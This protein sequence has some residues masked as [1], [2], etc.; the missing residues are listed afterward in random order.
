MLPGAVD[1]VRGWLAAADVV[2]LPS[3]W[4]GLSLTVLEAMAT[5]R[6]VVIS[7]VPGLTEALG[8]GTG[9]AVPPDDPV[10]LAEAIMRR[11]LDSGQ[12]EA[13]GTAA[14]RH[15]VQFDLRRTF[16]H[17]AEQTEAVLR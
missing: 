14:A 11:L 6:P 5:A 16:D 15:A 2:A 12:R 1:D 10:A 3:R 8:P 17:L 13:E 7:D 9:A 4:E